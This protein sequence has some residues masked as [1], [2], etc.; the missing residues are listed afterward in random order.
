MNSRERVLTALDHQEPDRVPIDLG[1][2]V[3]TSI[4][5][6][7]YAALREHLGLA[8]LPVRT[9]ETVQQIAV[10][11]DDMLD[12]FGV[13]VIP[14]FANP[15]VGYQAVFVDE[16]PRGESFRDE[17]R[18]H[19]TAAQGRLLLRLAGVSACRALDRRPT[20]NVMAGR[21]RCSP[22]PRPARA[23]P[24]A[25]CRQRSGPVRHGALWPRPVQPV[26]PCSRYGRGTHGPC[27]RAR[28]RPCI[29]PTAHR[30]HHLGPGALPRRRGR[31]GRRT[32]C[33]GRLDGPVRPARSRPHCTGG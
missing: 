27:G 19:A 7:T 3:V 22:L 29:L 17:F 11:D 12:L 14:V 1:G 4:A 2:T 10:V 25:T 9:L 18:R 23:G 24:R 15:P 21:H 31:P 8:H 26:A 13:D 20:E 5:I 16:G 28:I 6:S 30:H 32:L 33:R